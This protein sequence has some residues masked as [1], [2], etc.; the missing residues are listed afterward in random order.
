LTGMQ[1]QDP[2]YDPLEFMLEEAHKRGMEFHAWIN[3]DRAKFQYDTVNSTWHIVNT[4]PEWLYEY[5]GNLYFNFGIPQVRDYLSS[6]PAEIAKNYDIDGI[7]LD[8]YY[9]PFPVKDDTINDERTFKKYPNGEDNILD[10]R[11]KN[12]EI[13]V[14]DISQKIKK[15]KPQLPFGISPFPIWRN[16]EDDP[17]GSKTFAKTNSYSSLFADTDTWIRKGY[18]DYIAPQIYFTRYFNLAP[19][20]ELLSWWSQYDS[21]CPVFVGHSAFRIG[22]KGSLGRDTFWNP[23]EM[24]EQ[25]RLNRYYPGIEGSIFYSSMDLIKNKGGILDSLGQKLYKYPALCPIWKTEHKLAPPEKPKNV[26][27]EIIEDHVKI[28]WDSM[29]TRGEQQFSYLIYRFE[30][31]PYPDFDD[32]RNIAEIISGN[33]TSWTDPK[34]IT[35][36]TLYAISAVNRKNVESKPVLFLVKKNN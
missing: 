12:S 35:L 23:E 16:E 36:S 32:A 7:H 33:L 29:D 28:S 5:G 8:E 11:R 26:M 13:L 4:H 22:T 27:Q 21:I 25:I 30:T 34:P 2:N 20:E 10:W 3:I 14:R 6:I 19:Y 24:P 1:G 15:V 9:Y 18:V 17:R 31:S